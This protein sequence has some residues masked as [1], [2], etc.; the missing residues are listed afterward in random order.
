M[1]W[2][3][4]RLS[5]QLPHW[6]FANSSPLVI[7]SG[8]YFLTKSQYSFINH[9]ML[10]IAMQTVQMYFCPN[11][12]GSIRMTWSSL[13]VTAQLGTD[14]NPSSV[15]ILSDCCLFRLIPPKWIPSN[16]SGSSSA[17]WGSEMRGSILLPMLSADC[18]KQFV[19]WPMIWLKSITGH[20]WIVECF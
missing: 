12:R 5:F 14:R 17:R 1:Q 13:S 11:F 9:D 4:Q 16:R 7:L 19:A 18:A 6:C 8:S 3:H 15:L 20:N 10:F 2:C